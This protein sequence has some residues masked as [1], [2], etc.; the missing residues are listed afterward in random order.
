MVGNMCDLLT[1]AE[2]AKPGNSNPPQS[3]FARG[4]YRGICPAGVRQGKLSCILRAP[5]KM[6]T[7]SP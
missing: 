1:L 3:P 4:G 2:L 7:M 5:N 6:N